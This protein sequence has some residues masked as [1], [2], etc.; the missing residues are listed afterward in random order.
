MRFEV[1]RNYV[2]MRVLFTGR[3]RLMNRYIPW[4]DTL[5]SIQTINL[6]CKEHHKV[7]G[8]FSDERKFDGFIF[9][10]AEGGIWYNQYPNAHY[11]QLDDRMDYHAERHFEIKE[12]FEVDDLGLPIKD[13][14]NN[15]VVKTGP[16]AEEKWKIWKIAFENPFNL[17]R[18]MLASFIVA[19]IPQQEQAYRE[20]ARIKSI[21]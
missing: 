5:D 9:E 18:N 19:F 21:N 16:E 20:L 6:T 11:G 14:G 15:Y 8:E 1:G 3:P 17:P 4:E 7:P 13:S 2:F 12:L 10:D